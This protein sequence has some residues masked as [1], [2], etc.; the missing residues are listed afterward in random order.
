MILTEHVLDD[1][2]EVYFQRD[3]ATSVSKRTSEETRAAGGGVTG[4]Q[5]H[6][7]CR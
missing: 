2:G 6:R 1:L 7:K 5:L 3:L 4:A